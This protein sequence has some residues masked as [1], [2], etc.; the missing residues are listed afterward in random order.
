MN[1]D[2]DYNINNYTIE[3]LE[4]FLKLEKKFTLND[5]NEKC[6][7]INTI[8]FESKDYDKVYKTRIGKFLEEAKIKLSKH[9]KN[10]S[11]E[12]NGFIEHMLVILLL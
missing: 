9:I 11:E 1:I 12:N 4:N 6:N 10:I 5:I 7:K 3:E 8:I 2:F